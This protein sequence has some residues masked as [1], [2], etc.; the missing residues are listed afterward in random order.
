[1]RQCT[2][3]RQ[4]NSKSRRGAGDET[5]TRDI[6]L[7]R[8]VL[9]FVFKIAPEPLMS[10]ILGVLKGTCGSSTDTVLRGTGERPSTAVFPP[11]GTQACNMYASLI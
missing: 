7:G 4:P 6:Q 8:N 11:P 9:R 1:M 10:T 3:K 5:R 2:S